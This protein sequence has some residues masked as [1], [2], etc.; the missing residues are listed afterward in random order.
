MTRTFHQSV[1]VFIGFIIEKAYIS[2]R[3]VRFKNVNIFT[4]IKTYAKYFLF[5][6]NTF[7]HTFLVKMKNK[8]TIKILSN[9]SGTSKRITTLFGKIVHF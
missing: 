7:K 1:F 2:V 4:A 9:K 3:R 5:I 8:K 6:K